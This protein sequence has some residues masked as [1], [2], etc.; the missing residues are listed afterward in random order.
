M[1]AF[2][3]SSFPVECATFTE[4]LITLPFL[5]IRNPRQ[6]GIYTAADNILPLPTK[7]VTGYYF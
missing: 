6:L 3:I 5:S 4:S 1:Q 2:S 7:L